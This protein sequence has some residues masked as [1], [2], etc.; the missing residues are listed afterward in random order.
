MIFLEEYQESFRQQILFC[1]IQKSFGELGEVKRRKNKEELKHR[2]QRLLN[3][4]EDQ[5]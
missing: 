3:Q 5:K 1:L 2:V 4:R